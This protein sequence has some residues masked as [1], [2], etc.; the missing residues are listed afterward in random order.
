VS[1]GTW[2]E[3][4]EAVE[5]IAPIVDVLHTSGER[6]TLKLPNGKVYALFGWPGLAPGAKV[7]AIGAGEPLG[8]LLALHRYPVMTG[9]CLDGGGGLLPHRGEPVARLAEAIA[10]RAPKDVSGEPFAVQ[11]DA[12]WIQR[13]NRAIRWDGQRERDEGTV[14]QALASLVLEWSSR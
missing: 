6:G 4:P 5:R 2:P 14:K 8:E 3:L 12:L 11:G 10:G 1:K 13:G 9:T 7:I